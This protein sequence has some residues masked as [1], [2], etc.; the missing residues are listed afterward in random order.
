M[1]SQ[2]FKIL[3]FRLSETETELLSAERQHP[4]PKHN[5]LEKGAVPTKTI[6]TTLS[7]KSKQNGHEAVQKRQPLPSWSPE[8]QKHFRLSH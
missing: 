5:R 7:V 2:F 1:N 6:T 8:T 3:N 4:Q